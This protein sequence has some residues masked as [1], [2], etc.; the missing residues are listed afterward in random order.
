M[1]RTRPYVIVELGKAKRAMKE[2]LNIEFTWSVPLVD[3]ICERINALA[4]KTG[5]PTMWEVEREMNRLLDELIGRKTYW[6]RAEKPMKLHATGFLKNGRYLAAVVAPEEAKPWEVL[7]DRVVYGMLKDLGDANRSLVCLSE[8]VTHYLYY[9]AQK[10][11]VS[12]VA[13]CSIL[14][15][16]LLF[17]P[18]W[19]Q[20]EKDGTMDAF[21]QVHKVCTKGKTL[22]YKYE[23]TP[24]AD[25]F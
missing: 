15:A 6:S 23:A 8:G 22:K 13:S 14:L 9:Q 20:M 21:V 25:L 1:D 24:M 18:L 19:L 17:D 16:D 5:E 12:D 2:V 4:E 10:A 3:T 11:G 7:V